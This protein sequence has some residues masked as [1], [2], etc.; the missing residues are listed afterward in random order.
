MAIETGALWAETFT[1]EAVVP[2]RVVSGSGNWAVLSDGRR[3]FEALSGHSCL[4]LGHGHPDLLAAMASSAGRLSYCSPEHPSDPAMALAARLDGVLGGGYKL[5]YALSGASANEI[6]IEVVRRRWS[7]RGQ[8]E[9]RVILS[10]VPS[11]HGN[12]GEAQFATG[13]AAFRVDGGERADFVHIPGPMDE[14]GHLR[15]GEE[16]TEWLEAL[17]DRL[18]AGVLAGLIAEPVNFAGGVIVPEPGYFVALARF[19]ARHEVSFIVDEIITG[20]GRTGDWFGFEA[21]LAGTGLRPDLVCMGKGLTAGYFPLAAVAVDADIHAELAAADVTLKKV[22]TMA[23]HPVGCDVALAQIGIV[24]RDGL[25]AQVV[26]NA[27][28]IRAVL[29]GLEELAWVRDVRGR[30]H[31]WGIEF[32]AAGGRGRA[33]IASAVERHCLDR[34]LLVGAADGMLRINPPLSMSDAEREEMLTGLCAAVTA[35]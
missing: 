29:R 21:L 9:K 32:Q 20:F 8:P 33:D 7:A 5:R 10:L 28:R 30:G 6:A 13:Y 11:Y 25:R 26:E 12:L 22:I 31:M 23:G 27:A 34:G 1:G 17:V 24:E 18:G 15:S 19:C 14:S 2:V 35:A 4:N 16:I 3:M